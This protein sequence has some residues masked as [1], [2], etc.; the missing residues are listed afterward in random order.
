M[1]TIGLSAYGV[2]GV[3]LIELA[4]CADELGFDALWLGEHILRPGVQTTDHPS[5]G[6]AQHHTGPIIAQDTELIDP[7]AVH[8]AISAVTTRLKLGTATDL[9]PLRHPL[10]T[11]RTTITVSELS[12]GRVVLGV[13][14]G[15]AERRVRR[16][17]RSVRGPCHA[18]RSSGIAILRK[19]W[20]GD[21]FE[22]NRRHFQ[23]DRVQLH[24]DRCRLPVVLEVTDPRLCPGRRDSPM[25]VHLGHA[26]LRPGPWAW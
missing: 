20:S 19:A 11:A 26:D 9:L 10:Q 2:T 15:R 18:Y 1:G 23:F 22:Y 3:D 4:K 16:P 12:G 25:V 8:S 21:R 14:A 5:T 24:P 17:R 13:G 6:T 7:W